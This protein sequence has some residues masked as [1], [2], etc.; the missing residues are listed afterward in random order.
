M[1][2]NKHYIL[3]VYNEGSFSKA[4]EKLYISQ[5]SLSAS[6]KRIEEK[7]LRVKV[8]NTNEKWYGI[9]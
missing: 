2:T 3:A 6:I 9:T 1:F 8:L 7:K 4:A 5:P